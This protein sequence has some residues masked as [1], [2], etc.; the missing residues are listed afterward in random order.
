MKKLVITALVLTG[1]VGYLAISPTQAFAFGRD[2]QGPNTERREER[3]QNLADFIGVSVDEL[4]EARE[5]HT[6]KELL[7]EK[8]ITPEDMFKHNKEKM[9]ERMQKRG[10]SDEQINE[11][12]EHMKERHEKMKQWHEENPGEKPPFPHRGMHKPWQAE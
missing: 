7:E 4:K 2:G 5:N 8:G 6:M 10:L 1:L 12:I 3:I 9:L 11:R